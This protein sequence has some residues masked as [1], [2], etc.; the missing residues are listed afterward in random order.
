M[1]M[2]YNTAHYCTDVETYSNL[3]GKLEGILQQAEPYLRSSD[4]CGI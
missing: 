3:N 2:P 1:T 4:Y